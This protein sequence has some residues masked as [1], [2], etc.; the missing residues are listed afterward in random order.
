MAKKLLLLL[1][2]AFLFAAC[3]PQPKLVS[4]QRF[5]LDTLVTIKVYPNKKSLKKILPKAF[6]AMKQTENRFNLYQK[7]SETYKI[8]Q[9]AGQQRKVSQAMAELI[10]ESLEVSRVTKGGFDITIR[11][12]FALYHFEGKGQVPTRQALARALN[13]VGFK[14]LIFNYRTKKLQ[15]Q[16]KMALDFGGIMKGKAVDAAARLLKKNGV[17]SGLIT[18]VSSISVLGPKPDGSAWNIG[19]QSPDKK[20]LVGFLKIKKGNISTSGSYQQF[21]RKNGRLYHH[22]I[23]PKTGLPASG[24]KSVT[25]VTDK[26][27]AFAD[28][29][30]TGLFIMGEQA[31][32]KLAQKLADVEAIFINQKG[33]VTVTKGLKRKQPPYFQ[34][35]K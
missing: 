19:L 8:N 25:V 29:L 3:Q 5:I 30:S 20:N 21:F 11:P 32:L 6:K 15:L 16:P 33:K 2:L 34:L 12:V 1:L 9:T 7:N 14:K 31:G 27:N 23:N 22:L 4:K 26:S 18:S 28:A 17:K 24:L 13:Y 35:L 10:K